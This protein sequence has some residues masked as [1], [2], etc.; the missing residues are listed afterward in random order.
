MLRYLEKMELAFHNDS[1]L[2]AIF[3]IDGDI[4]RMRAVMLELKA[5]YLKYDFDN[6]RKI[7]KE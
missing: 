4:T 5:N 3:R 7:L 2:P 1:D 6:F